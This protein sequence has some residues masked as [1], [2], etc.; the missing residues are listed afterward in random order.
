MDSKEKTGEIV[1]KMT[2]PT[3]KSALSDMRLS[4]DL[5]LTKDGKVY[6]YVM[7]EYLTKMQEYGI[8]CKEGKREDWCIRLQEL[9]DCIPEMCDAE[10]L[11]EACIFEMTAELMEKMNDEFTWDEIAEIVSRQGHTGM[12]ISLTGQSLLEFSPYGIG[13]VDEI[14]KPR[15]TYSGM[16]YLS[17][18]YN[19]EK[20]KE[21]KMKKQLARRLVKSLSARINQF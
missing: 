2:E 14:I 15:G 6:S 5:S 8:Y 9:V 17:K 1:R 4:Y 20:R 10:W 7:N 3:S 19:L 21:G 16:T 13:F 12:S 18:A 11:Y